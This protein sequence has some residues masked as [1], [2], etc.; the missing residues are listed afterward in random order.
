MEDASGGNALT[1]IPAEL[2]WSPMRS[3]WIRVVLE[4]AM[5]AQET[6]TGK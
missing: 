2:R 4:V 5:C 3:G 1:I 6:L